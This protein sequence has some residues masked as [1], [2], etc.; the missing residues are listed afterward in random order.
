M[1]E[2][3]K[4]TVTQKSLFTSPSFLFDDGLD[5]TYDSKV[6]M[7]HANETSA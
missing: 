2:R 1:D 7:K 6:S 4:A 3:F 5:R